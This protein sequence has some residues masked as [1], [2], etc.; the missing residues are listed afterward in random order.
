MGILEQRAIYEMDFPERP[1]VKAPG[2]SEIPLGAFPFILA[3]KH[4]DGHQ[5][6]NL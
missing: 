1:H 3:K 6:N 5:S 2:D 4:L